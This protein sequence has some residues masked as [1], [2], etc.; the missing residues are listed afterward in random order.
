MFRPKRPVP[1]ATQQIVEAEL[2]RLEKIGVSRVNY[3]EWAPIVA[4]KNGNGMFEF[5][6]IFLNWP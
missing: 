3:S 2:D 5:V 1:L 6:Q 4:V